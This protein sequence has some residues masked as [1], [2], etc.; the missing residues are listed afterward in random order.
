MACTLRF[1]NT[2]G[3]NYGDSGTRSGP[4]P[5]CG[6]HMIVEFDEDCDHPPPGMSYEEWEDSFDNEEDDDNE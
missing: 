6:A 1:C 3:C 4:C 2:P 5:E